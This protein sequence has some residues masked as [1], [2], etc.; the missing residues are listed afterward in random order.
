MADEY[1][2]VLDAVLENH[3]RAGH[4]WEGYYLGENGHVSFYE[5]G[6]AIGEALVQMGLADDAEPT[7][8]TDEELVKY[9]GFVVCDLRDLFRTYCL[10]APFPGGGKLPR[11]DVSLQ[12]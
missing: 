11:Y 9:G 7:P 5:I 10:T 6:R 12:G 3:G 2:V 8:L 1:I 4:G